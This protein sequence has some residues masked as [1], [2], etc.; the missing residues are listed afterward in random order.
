MEVQDNSEKVSW[1]KYDEIEV[2]AH[3]IKLVA[4]VSNPH[5]LYFY[6][7]ATNGPSM[8]RIK[9]LSQLFESHKRWSQEDVW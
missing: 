9:S 1:G 6:F 2:G 4:I 3:I 7:W 8:E 5:V